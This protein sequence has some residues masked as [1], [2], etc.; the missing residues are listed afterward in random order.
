MHRRLRACHTT[1]VAGSLGGRG[2]VRAG[3]KRRLGRSLALPNTFAS[4]GRARC[5]DRSNIRVARG[6]SQDARSRHLAPRWS[7]P[8]ET[9]A[10]R[11]PRFTPASAVEAEA[12]PL[13]NPDEAA[14]P[15][16]G[17]PRP[18]RA[19]VELARQLLLPPDPRPDRGRARGAGPSRRR[20]RRG[21]RVSR[22]RRLA[23]RRLRPTSSSSW[24]GASRC[25][26]PAGRTTS[27]SSARSS[28]RRRGLPSRGQCLA[29]AV[30]V[31]DIDHATSH[32]LRRAG[33][34]C[35]YLPL[36]Y[37]AG[38]ADYGPVPELPLHDGT[39]HL[40]EEVRRSPSAGGA[41]RDRPIDFSSS[42]PEPR[43][44][45]RSSPAP[46]PS[47]PIVAPTST[48]STRSDPAWSAGR[49]PWTRRR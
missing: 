12:V 25:D 37:A 44:A 49:R 26:G 7:A 23:N 15:D 42:E 21:G 16:A 13:A 45:R 31:W 33:I 8:D 24:D 34:A 19:P 6:F 17:S 4:R 41:L 18:V 35:D 9:D 43:D 2:S 3:T 39:R 10:A 11:S 36:G 22:R 14:C 5:F 32:R 40:G 47:W 30:A 29:R 48:S 28:L 27:S 1:G 46:R 38:Y 20:P